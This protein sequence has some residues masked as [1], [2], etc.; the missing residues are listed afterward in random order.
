MNETRSFLRSA[1]AQRRS[2][3]AREEANEVAVPNGPG[4]HE[5]ASS[6]R[7]YRRHATISL[8]HCLANAQSGQQVGRGERRWGEIECV[9]E[10]RGDPALL[11]AVGAHQRAEAEYASDLLRVWLANRRL[12]R[13]TARRQRRRNAGFSLRINVNSR[14]RPGQS[15][16]KISKPTLA[17]PQSHN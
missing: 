3:K 15:H 2:G 9:R 13:Q 4:F 6:M 1:S 14:L 8:Y 5:E 7:A 12:Q 17:R 11:A 10:D 16:N